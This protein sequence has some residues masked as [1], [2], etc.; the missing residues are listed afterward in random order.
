MFVLRDRDIHVHTLALPPELQQLVPRFLS[1]C[2]DPTTDI[3]LIDNDARQLYGMLSHVAP[4]ESDLGGATVLRIETDG[5]LDQL[6]FSLL[7]GPESGYLADR[8]EIAFSQ[9]LLC[10]E[11]LAGSNLAGKRCAGGGCLAR[12]LFACVTRSGPG[13]YRGSWTVLQ[14]GSDF[15]ARFTRKGRVLNNCGMRNSSTL[16]DTRLLELTGPDW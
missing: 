13:G 7:R 1:L 15:R 9:N 4:L 5:I 6:P 14:G 12:F 16:P 8:F 10:L 11:N 2:S 3:N